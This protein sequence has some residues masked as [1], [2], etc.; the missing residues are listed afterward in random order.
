MTDP[1]TAD[2]KF[3][4]KAFARGRGA[5]ARKGTVNALVARDLVWF[6]N[7]YDDSPEL[8]EKGRR[9]AERL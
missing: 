9:E 1:L 2:M 7:K 4:L 5:I 3:A 8:T 6:P